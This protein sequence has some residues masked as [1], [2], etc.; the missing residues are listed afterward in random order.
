[1]K[2]ATVTIYICKTKLERSGL[3]PWHE[4]PGGLL[5]FQTLYKI[6]ILCSLMTHYAGLLAALFQV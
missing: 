3:M 5:W 2:K 6:V 1:M 4:T